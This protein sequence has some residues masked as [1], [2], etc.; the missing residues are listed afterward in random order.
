MAM[1]GVPSSSSV[2]LHHVARLE[3]RNGLRLGVEAAAH[4]GRARV[5]LRDELDGDLV[6]ES[7]VRRRPDGA[8]AAVPDERVEAILACD[9]STRLSQV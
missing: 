7:Q 5:G 2:D 1:N 8:H 6:A 4:V 9:R 3:A